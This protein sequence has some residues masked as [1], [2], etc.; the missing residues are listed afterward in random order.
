L[1]ADERIELALDPAQS[2]LDGDYVILEA[3][4]GRLDV[5]YLPLDPRERVHLADDDIVWSRRA[6]G[7]IGELGVRNQR[8]QVLTTS[9]QR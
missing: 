3:T 4:N 9:S 8:V 1:A 2:R 7:K 5:R 6:R